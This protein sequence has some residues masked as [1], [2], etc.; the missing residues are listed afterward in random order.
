MKR[1]HLFTI[2]SVLLCSC[3][4]K[5]QEHTQQSLST[6]DSS[7]NAQVMPQSKGAAV[8]V[9]TQEVNDTAFVN[10]KTRS[11]DFAFEMRYATTNNFLEKKVYD[12]S[13]CLVRYEV[14]KALKM[15]NDSLMQL[16]YKI[17]F[18]DCFRPVEVQKKMWKIYPDAHYV[19]NPYTTGSVHNKG[20][21]VDITLITLRGDLVNMGTDFDFFGEEAHHNYQKLSD[22]ILAN[23][24]L[25]KIIMQ[26]FGFDAISTEWWHYNYR[27][28]AKYGISDEELC[29]K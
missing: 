5:Q 17:K 14:F 4:P 7:S 18:F 6:I 9:A 20:A 24:S 19:A 12:C 13:N 10:V 29:E 22:E 25:L 27:G 23:R 15:A 2:I 28:R 26:H 16:G 8:D 1:L 21:A 11:N 3:Q